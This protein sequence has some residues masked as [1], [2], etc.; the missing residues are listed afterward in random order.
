VSGNVLGRRDDEFLPVN[1]WIERYSI[2]FAP[3]N[4]A[5]DGGAIEHAGQ[6]HVVNILGRASNFVAAFLARD[7]GSHDPWFRSLRQFALLA[8]CATPVQTLLLLRYF[9]TKWLRF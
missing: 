9:A 2:D 7:G 8:W 3:S 6:A 5:A 1:R 4:L